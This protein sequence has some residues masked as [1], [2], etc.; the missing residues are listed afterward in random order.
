MPKIYL[1]NALHVDSIGTSAVYA[2]AFLHKLI[3]GRVEDDMKSQQFFHEKALKIQP[4]PEFVKVITSLC[5]GCDKLE[6][7]EAGKEDVHF[8][9][10]NLIVYLSI[11]F[12][13]DT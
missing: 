3:F 10:G 5:E 6:L 8:E 13:L 11:V 7:L 12:I 9:K 2:A 4:S 1:D